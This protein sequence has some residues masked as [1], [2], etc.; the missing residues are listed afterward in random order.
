MEE[1]DRRKSP[2]YH[3]IITVFKEVESLINS[4]IAYIFPYYTQH[5][6]KHSLRI[7]EYMYEI[8]DDIKQLND[9]EIAFLIYAALLHDIGMSVTQKEI[10]DI[11][12]QKS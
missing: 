7:M 3:Q 10:E 8:I 9:L 4:R 2:F 6:I 1:L 5:D 11:K 12:K